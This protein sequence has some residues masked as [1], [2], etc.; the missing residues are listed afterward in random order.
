MQATRKRR[1]R[2]RPLTAEQ[3]Q[4]AESY[5]PMARS[6]AR[7]LR[8]AWPSVRDEFESA[9][10][11]ALVQAAQS[12]D[13]ARCVKFG[14]FARFRIKGAL[15]DVQRRMTLLGLRTEN[16]PAET[17]RLLSMGPK[18]EEHARPVCAVPRQDELVALEAAD[19]FEALLRKLPER[20]AEACREMYQNGCSQ[21]E[22]AERL[23]CSQSR[24][25]YMHREALAMLNGSWYDAL[26]KKTRPDG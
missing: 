24:L 25:S 9:A 22:A 13:P 20:H 6:L 5:M 14:T 23:G 2:R 3:K 26:S 11:F 12:Y 10:L 7:P 21:A 17:P 8:E 1:V 16:E 4:L 19:A 18:T 15:R